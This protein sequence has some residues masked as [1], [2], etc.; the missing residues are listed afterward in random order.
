MRHDSKIQTHGNTALLVGCS[1]IDRIVGKNLVVCIG[2]LFD[3]KAS[4]T[5]PLLIAYWFLLKN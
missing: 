5:V 4:V 1:D 2:N 3:N